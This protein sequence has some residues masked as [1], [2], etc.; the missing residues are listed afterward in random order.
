M[1]RTRGAIDH[2]PRD[3]AAW[4]RCTLPPCEENRPACT[5]ATRAAISD[6]VARPSIPSNT[7]TGCSV[8][9]PLAPSRPGAGRARWDRSPTPRPAAAITDR[10]ARSHTRGRRHPATDYGCPSEHE[11]RPMWE[12]TKNTKI[13]QWD[14][15]RPDPGSTR[16]RQAG[17]ECRAGAPHHRLREWSDQWGRQQGTSRLLPGT[18]FLAR[19]S[20]CWCEK[21]ISFS[22]AS[23][24]FSLTPRS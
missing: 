19:T 17:I 12:R 9:F 22:R 18:S 20:A 16:S 2:Q 14:D 10:I 8:P 7:R 13:S 3:I 21:R 23:S 15:Y 1:M 11:T 24:S 4:R 5:G 6:L